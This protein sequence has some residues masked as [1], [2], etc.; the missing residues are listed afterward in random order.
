[1]CLIW[2]LRMVS[3]VASL[4]LRGMAGQWI[5]ES[6][7]LYYACAIRVSGDRRLALG[8]GKPGNGLAAIC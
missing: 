1:M 7:S 5:E 2:L 6:L 3:V 4:L 8:E